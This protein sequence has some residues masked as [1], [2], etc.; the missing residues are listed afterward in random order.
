MIKVGDP[1]Q[2]PDGTWF[3]HGALAPCQ[4]G[5]SEATILSAISA[6]VGSVD[7][8]RALM[9]GGARRWEQLAEQDPE[10]HRALKRKLRVIPQPAPAP[11][12][13]PTD[14]EDE[15]EDA[16]TSALEDVMEHVSEEMEAPEVAAEAPTPAPEEIALEAS[17]PIEAP[18]TPAATPIEVAPAI[19]EAAQADAHP[20][21]QWTGARELSRL[22]Q[23]E[24]STLR[25]WTQGGKLESRPA[26]PASGLGPRALE[27]RIPPG[28]PVPTPAAQSNVARLNP[29]PKAPP[30]RWAE[31]GT[32]A[33]YQWTRG[34][35][36]MAQLLDIETSTVPYWVQVGKLEQRPCADHSRACEYR[37]PPGRPVPLPAQT[38]GRSQR[39]MREAAAQTPPP[40]PQTPP[41]PAASSSRIEEETRQHALLTEA[42]SRCAELDAQI[43][44]LTAQLA[45][46]MQ[47]EREQLLDAGDQGVQLAA[48]IEALEARVEALTAQL[49]EREAQLAARIEEIEQVRGQELTAR[50]RVQQLEALVSGAAQT[51]VS[52]RGVLDEVARWMGASVIGLDIRLETGARIGVTP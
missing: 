8:A 40:A 50:W 6:R 10:L 16:P 43:E 45:A 23:V 52:L 51:P 42:R 35:R 9:S 26:D 30:Q 5:S 1:I 31:D 7:R 38:G 4:W 46:Q 48:Q 28:R 11:A 15:E 14:D 18:P 47:R 27:Y 3:V 49:A 19:E 22:F 39:A 29:A 44:D 34:H 21:Y 2:C 20:A 13:P 25:M 24:K 37:V 33:A 41:A 12:P 36:A 32:H 17:T